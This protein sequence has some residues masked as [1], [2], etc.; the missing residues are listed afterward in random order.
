MNKKLYKKFTIIFFIM[1][2][3]SLSTVMIFN[4]FIDPGNQFYHANIIEYKMSQALLQDKKVIVQANYNERFLQKTMLQKLSFRPDILVLGSSHIMPLTNDIFHTKRFF[5]ASVSSASLE[6]DIALYYIL[7]KNGYQP[8]TVIICLDPWIVSKANPEV[9]WKTEYIEEYLEG[10]KLIL[11][12]SISLIYLNHIMSFF[13]K[14][15]QLLSFKYL[16]SSIHKLIAIIK[17]QK[18]HTI[19]QDISTL[20]AKASICPNCFVR[21]P[22]GSRLPTP[23]E[24]AT[25]PEEANLYVLNNINSW[26][27][28]WTQSTLDSNYTVIFE[29]F[30]QYLLQRN[31]KVV[32]YF[33]PMQ[34]L[35]YTQL[36]KKNTNYRMVFVAETYFQKIAK[37]YRLQTIGAYDPM[38]VHLVTS[39]FIDSWHL[40]KEGITKLF[41]RTWPQEVV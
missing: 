23:T 12:E 11:G 29:R 35:E 4:F 31:I 1:A 5:N 6:D 27:D 8:K 19:L 16:E 30:V 18:Q 28:F 40:K 39:D 34:P 26:K 41:V 13:E 21:Q 3:I 32:F 25:T 36:V 9:L 14:Y 22:D 17:H 10:K 7:Q 2:G 20:D 37:K 15:L 38:K 24:E 33:P